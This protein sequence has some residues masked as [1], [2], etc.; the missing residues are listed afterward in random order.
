MSILKSKMPWF[1]A[2]LIFVQG[3]TYSITMIHTEGQASDVYDDQ[4]TESDEFS[5]SLMKK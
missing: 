4:Q 3:C 1:I 2:A 5:A